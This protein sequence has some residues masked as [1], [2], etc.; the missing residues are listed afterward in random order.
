MKVNRRRLHILAISGSIVISL[1]TR[2][3]AQT[4]APGPACLSVKGTVC[5]GDEVDPAAFGPGP[6]N[7]TSTIASK[8]EVSN[9]ALSE[10]TLLD[11]QTYS[12]VSWADVVSIRRGTNI[13]SITYV[14]GTR[15]GGGSGS[16]TYD[17]FVIAGAPCANVDNERRCFRALANA[18]KA[19]SEF[20]WVDEFHMQ[21]NLG[22]RFL[23]GT[24]GDRMVMDPR[25]MF[26]TIDSPVEAAWLLRATNIRRD[27]S[28]FLA[29]V[30]HVINDCPWTTEP[31]VY[32]LDPNGVV[33]ERT[34]GPI[35]TKNVCT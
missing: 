28:S 33:S 18:R 1:H 34:R 6:T 21:Y 20:R 17:P 11:P 24:K 16:A 30:T 2:S 19:T 7:A 5:P 31:I 9:G 14:G 25:A 15:S 10:A 22:F 23:V 35:E 12:R 27:G 29:L 3:W 26:G 32:T 8:A 13:D 4:V